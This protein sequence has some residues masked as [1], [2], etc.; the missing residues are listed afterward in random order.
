MVIFSKAPFVLEVNVWWEVLLNVSPVLGEATEYFLQTSV[1][2]T[3]PY[4]EN[5]GEEGQEVGP[6]VGQKRGSGGG[7]AS[8]PKTMK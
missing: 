6:G 1:L 5:S 7:S 3:H 2:V 4:Q 8:S